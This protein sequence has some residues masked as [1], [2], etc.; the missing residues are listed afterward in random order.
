MRP[1][2][3]DK[4]FAKCK[5]LPL[6]LLL[7]LLAGLAVPFAAL[8]TTEQVHRVQVAFTYRFLL[9]TEWPEVA[10]AGTVQKIVVGIQGQGQGQG[11]DAFGNFFEQLEGTPIDGRTLEVRRL[12]ADAPLEDIQQ[13]QLLFIGSSL[14]RQYKETIHL[15]RDL[16]ILTVS[17]ID[18][19]AEAGGIIGFF[20]EE[21]KVKFVV[22][23]AAAERAGLVFR[24]QLLR[25][26]P[27]ILDG[28]HGTR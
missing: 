27:R 19:F 9:F 20:L 24:S 10:D 28:D 22:N 18:G 8:S 7:I 4:P 14:K 16:P 11:Q 17:D 13:C 3:A 12:P 25:V 6:T 1:R 2:Y 15:L 23:R 5:D 21:S 26:A